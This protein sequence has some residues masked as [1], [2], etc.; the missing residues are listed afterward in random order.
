MPRLDRL[1]LV[2]LALLLPLLSVEVV[3]LNSGGADLDI[4]PSPLDLLSDTTSNDQ[5]LEEPLV[6]LV[7]FLHSEDEFFSSAEEEPDKT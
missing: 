7:V 6:A 3:F 1:E 2:T 5:D 4:L